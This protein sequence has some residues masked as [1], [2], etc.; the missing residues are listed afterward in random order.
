MMLIPNKDKPSK[1]DFCGAKF[2]ADQ[3]RDQHVRSA[4]TNER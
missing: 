3:A 1:C 2:S 4:H